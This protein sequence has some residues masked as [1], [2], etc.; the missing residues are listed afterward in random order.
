MKSSK[1]SLRKR[2]LIYPRFQVTLIAVNTA[3]LGLAFVGVGIQISRS[4]QQIRDMGAAAGMA[5]D[6]AYFKFLAFQTQML[7]SQ[8]M[9]A[10]VIGFLISLV[11]SLFFSH[12]LAGPIVRLVSYLSDATKSAEKP[13]A[14][15][16]FRKHDFFLE[17]PP[18]VN[19][20]LSASRNES[21]KRK[22]V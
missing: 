2:F 3:I 8:L 9:G 16:K 15:L 4:F 19:A 14:P 12:R 22:V 11:F 5:P 7:H 17:I 6:H 1:F 21:E 20:A 18:L 10:F 13:L